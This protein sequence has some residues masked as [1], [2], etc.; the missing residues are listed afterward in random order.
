MSLFDLSN[1]VCLVTGSTKGIGMATTYR[2]LEHGA[3]VVV[4]GRGEAEAQARAAELNTQFGSGRAIGIGFD[5][6]DRASGRALIDRTLE[7]WGRIDTLMCNAAH[8]L[9]GRLE[10]MDEEVELIGTSFESNVRNYAA[11]TRYVVPH[12]RSQGGGSII[13]TLS[14]AGFIAA[15]PYLPYGIAKSSLDYMTKSLAV[16][17]GPDNIRVN[18]IIPGGIRT[19]RKSALEES[20][21]ADKFVEKIPMGRRG[22]ADDIAAVAVLLAA[23]GGSYI[24]GQSIGVEGGMLLKGSEGITEGYDFALSMQEQRKAEETEIL[25]G[26]TN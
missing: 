10:S 15:P 19:F 14:A 6:A 5:L 20:G 2:M 21:A 17:F 4:T 25:S 23:P 22:D 3:R 7:K 16:D 9:L 11:L 12:M 26:Y 13:Y 24:T 8:I 1:R 18:A